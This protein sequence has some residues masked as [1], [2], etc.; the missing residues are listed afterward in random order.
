MIEPDALD[1]FILEQVNA[2]KWR[3]SWELTLFTISQGF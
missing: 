3:V 2:G 1:V